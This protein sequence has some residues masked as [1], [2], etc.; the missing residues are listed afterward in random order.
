MLQ[1]NN[2]KRQILLFMLSQNLSIFGSSV[3]GFSIIWYVTLKTSSGVW[4][5]VTSLAA[6]L[7]QNHTA[8][9]R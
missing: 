6:M 7:P 4:I 9:G 8:H 3:V 5:T 2:W 1:K